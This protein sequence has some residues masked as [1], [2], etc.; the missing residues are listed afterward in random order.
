MDHNDSMSDTSGSAPLC[1]CLGLTVLKQQHE[2]ENLKLRLF[3]H[4]YC[5]TVF[6]G[7]MWE[8]NFLRTRCGCLNCMVRGSVEEDDIDA[9]GKWTSMNT[10]NCVWQ[11]A[12]QQEMLARGLTF[13]VVYGQGNT[14]P[15]QKVVG[16]FD[17]YPEYNCHFVIHGERNDWVQMGL[18]SLLGTARH[19]CD[20]ELQKYK[21]LINDFALEY[22]RQSM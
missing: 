12:F 18:G 5:K 19:E 11:D 15:D 1:L 10:F 2:I 3:W 22:D 14:L 6:Q 4:K 16:G 13:Q 8:F 17:C 21:K 9:D 20:A 7:T